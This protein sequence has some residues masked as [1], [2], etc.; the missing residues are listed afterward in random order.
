MVTDNEKTCAS[1]RWWIRCYSQ[2]YNIDFQPLQS[3]GECK[4]A[5]SPIYKN[6]DDW[7]GQHEPKEEKSDE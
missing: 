1:C 3:R 4:C 2:D 7:C 5:P 6:A